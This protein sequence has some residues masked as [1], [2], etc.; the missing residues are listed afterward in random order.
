MAGNLATI[1]SRID[2]TKP[3]NKFMG[4]DSLVVPK[5]YEKLTPMTITK[6]T[7]LKQWN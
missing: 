2:L 3:K 7:G 6:F 5:I 4:V 1:R